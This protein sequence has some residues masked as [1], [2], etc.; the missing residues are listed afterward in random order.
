MGQI[1][2]QQSLDPAFLEETRFCIFKG[3]PRSQKRMTTMVYFNSPVFPKASLPI[4]SQSNTLNTQGHID[5]TESLKTLPECS[6]ELSKISGAFSV[7]I[8][9]EYSEGGWQ[10]A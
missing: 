3:D 8:V 2:G 1:N 7:D 5:L 9:E 4:R 10:G 6:T